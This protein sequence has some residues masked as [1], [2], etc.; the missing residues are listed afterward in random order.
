MKQSPVHLLYFCLAAIA[1][2]AVSQD[3]LVVESAGVGIGTDMP[4]ATLHV[5]ADD[6]TAN[7]RV[8]EA[9]TDS[10][11]DG[12]LTLV[13]AQGAPIISFQSNFRTWTFFGGNNFGIANPDFPDTEMLVSAN[14]DLTITGNFFS[15]S[16]NPSPCGP[17]YVFEDSYALVPLEDVAGFVMS[18]R[19][20]PGIPSAEELT[21]PVNVSE[22]QM[23]LLEKI[24]ELT[25]YA[26][27][28]DRESRDQAA[29][30]ARKDA[31]LAELELEL[32]TLRESTGDVQLLRKTVATM[33]AEL[34]AL[35]DRQRD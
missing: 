7:L 6:E 1:L 19:H 25:L 15:V 3:Q 32:A 33:Q 14:G 12:L 5:Y 10:G 11:N 31:R 34:A 16:C 26:I 35:Q 24:E 22:L 28:Q 27:Q 18:R 13:S 21:G 4:S 29:Q 23:K 8:Q 9:G 2:P 17:D 20:L 30:L